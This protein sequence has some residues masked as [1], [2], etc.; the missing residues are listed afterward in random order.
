MTGFKIHS[1][2][3]DK[4]EPKS[5]SEVLEML[6]AYIKR[7][8]LKPIRGAGRWIGFGLVA[9]LSLSIG[10][11][12]GALGVL[13]LVQ[14]TMFGDSQTWSWVNYIVALGVCSVVLVFTISRIRKGSLEK[15]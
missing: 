1:S 4:S 10:I 9:A 12:L 8:T 7:E 2:N 3:S 15:S 14:S 13:R 5:A 6:F 11:V